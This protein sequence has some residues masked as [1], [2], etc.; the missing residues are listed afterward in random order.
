M[1]WILLE[2]LIALA[3]LAAI[4]WWTIAPHRKRRD[5]D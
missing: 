5:D 3:I 2:S 4:V 1:G